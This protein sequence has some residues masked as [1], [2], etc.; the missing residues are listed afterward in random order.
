MSA[1]SKQAVANH[2][3][4]ERESY[5]WYKSKGICPKCRKEWAAPGRVFCPDC[6][7]K[8][9]DETMKYGGEYNARK[10]K[11]RRERLKEQGLCVRC[12]RPAVE[13]RVLCAECA[14]KNSEA[15]QV[16]KMKKRIARENA[17]EVQHGNGKNP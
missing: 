8:K 5:A 1:I 14:R 17:K 10:C 11:E 6:L 16:R 4:A 9:R 12:A 13:G 15:Q 3:K 2:R 7:K